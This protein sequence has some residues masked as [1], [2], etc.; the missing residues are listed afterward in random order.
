MKEFIKQSFTYAK[1]YLFKNYTDIR[2]KPIPTEPIDVDNLIPEEDNP[3]GITMYNC[4]VASDPDLRGPGCVKVYEKNKKMRQYFN[5]LTPTN[6]DC[7]HK[8]GFE[9]IDLLNVKKAKEGDA[10]G[11]F[12]TTKDK[13]IKKYYGDPFAKI[14]I[15]KV[16]RWIIKDGDKVTIKVYSGRKERKVNNLYFTKTACSTTITFDMKTGNFKVITYNRTKKDPNKAFHS[17]SFVALKTALDFM[18][19]PENKMDRT[20]PFYDEFIKEFNPNTFQ[21]AVR[22][23]IELNNLFYPPVAID[24]MA[25]DFS[26]KW[27]NKFVELK[28]IKCPNVGV[29]RLIKYFYPTEKYLKKNDRKL[30][31]SI[32][33]RFK[34]KSNVLIK[35]LHQYP[36]TN[37]KDIADLCTLLGKDYSKYLG[38]IKPH[39]FYDNDNN[40]ND[41][42]DKT[43]I[44]SENDT[45]TR[46]VLN[47]EK[48]NIIKIIND[49]TD[50]SIR[51][52]AH[53]VV[54]TLMDHFDMLEKTHPHYP[55]FRLTSQTAETF[56]TEHVQLSSISSQIQEGFSTHL[57]FDSEVIREIEKPF[58]ISYLPPINV[59]ALVGTFDG[60][61]EKTFEP[62]LL[63]TSEDYIEEGLYMHHCVAGYIKYGGRAIII[64]LRCGS[65]RVTC[66]FDIK[67]KKCHQ[68]RFFTNDPY[69]EY[70]EKALTALKHRISG[71]P[72]LIAPIDI[73][74]IPYVVN[75]V[76]VE[77]EETE[78]QLF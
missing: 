20:S 25:N 30:I 68:A 38:N 69:P 7:H 32:L 45:F 72:F 56:H 58:Q 33:D 26:D 49:S 40:S 34:I 77:I 46:E 2:T 4:T 54:R 11:F 43:Y 66:E 1:I 42:T 35:I 74:K 5:T 18:Y 12:E 73:K 31:A 64:S 6:Y 8:I 15:R 41:H 75:G 60:I 61:Y 10:S 14:E 59:H 13:Q 3:L 24:I 48:E 9:I 65:D 28:K 57:I 63:K 70:F 22:E 27:L 29:K 19:R 17:N 51:H 52:R 23:A 53:G 78:D 62:H 21:L 76:E 47:V 39:F 16:E 55:E 71:I 67:F 50:E 37:I 44:L 36:H